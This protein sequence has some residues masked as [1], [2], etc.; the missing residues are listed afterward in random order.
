L[1]ELVS[2]LGHELQHA[3][4]IAAAP[5][6]RDLATQRNFYLRTGYETRGGGYF[7]SEAALE[8]GRRVAAEFAG[9]RRPR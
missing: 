2:V 3:V 8:A 4:E 6:V 5:E 7:E 9:C 1:P